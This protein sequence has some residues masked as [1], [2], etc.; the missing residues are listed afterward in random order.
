MA[1]SHRFALKAGQARRCIWLGRCVAMSTWSTTP[2]AGAGDIALI[3]QVDMP[4]RSLSKAAATHQT[5]QLAGAIGSTGSDQSIIDDQAAPLKAL[6]IV[7]SGMVDAHHESAA[8]DD[9]QQKNSTT[10]QGKLP[11]LTDPAIIQA[12]K[13][14]I[15]HVAGKNLQYATGETLT[16]ASGEDSN[17][18][19][20]G[21]TR[22][23]S[24]QAIGLL[25]GAIK[26]GDGNTGLKLIAARDDID[27]QA[28]SDEMKFLARKDVKLVS[29]TQHIDF[30]AAKKIHLAVAGGASITIDGGI[31]VQCPGTITVHASKKS[32]TGPEKQSYAL[33]TFPQNVCIKCLLKAMNSGS[34]LSK[35]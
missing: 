27:L 31:T 11:H 9:A 3:K 5:V 6:Q 1:F 30:A 29:A 19:I 2:D 17:F 4:A 33:P 23:H 13:A 24:G 25:A 21:R 22:I 10:G 34:A 28:Q 26:A 18:A 14:G 8:V 32:F 12:G 15:A 35:V 16:F 7:A 20:A